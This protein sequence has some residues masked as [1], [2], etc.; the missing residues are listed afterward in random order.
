MPLVTV[1]HASTVRDFVETERANARYALAQAEREQE[2][3][4]AWMWRRQAM[5]HYAAAALMLAWRARQREARTK[6]RSVP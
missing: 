2:P 1:G 5:H 6:L 3:L 4:F